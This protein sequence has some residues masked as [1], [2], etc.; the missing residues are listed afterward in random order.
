MLQLLITPNYSLWEI[1][2][3]VLLICFKLK[4][5]LTA[6]HCRLLEKMYNIYLDDVSEF[7]MHWLNIVCKPNGNL[8]VNS[9]ACFLTFF[10]GI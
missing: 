8:H 10:H 1:Q 4:S 7:N 2:F 5:N 9:S 3:V 6:M